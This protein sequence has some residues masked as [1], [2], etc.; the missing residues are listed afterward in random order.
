MRYEIRREIRHSLPAL[1]LASALLACSGDGGGDPGPTAPRTTT[2]QFV[3]NSSTTVDP[4]IQAAFPGCVNGIGRTHIHPS[5]QGYRLVVFDVQ[6]P[7][8]FTLT[9]TDVPVGTENR[10]RVSDPNACDTHVTGASTE[11]VFANNVRLTRIVDTPGTGI[12]PGLAFQVSAEGTVT[13]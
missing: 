11:N 12:E 7:D 9:F 1:V 5:W 2:V 10:I 6:P 13:P 4:A 8:R 3:Y